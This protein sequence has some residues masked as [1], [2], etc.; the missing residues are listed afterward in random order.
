VCTKGRDVISG[1]Q[2]QT[3]EAFSLSISLLPWLPKKQPGVFY[4]ASFPSSCYLL[5][6]LLNHTFHT[7][8]HSHIYTFTHSHIHSFTHSLIQTFTH[9]HIHTFTHS[10]IHSFTH[11]HI[12]NQLLHRRFNQQLFC[13]GRFIWLEQINL[14]LER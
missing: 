10:H 7:F 12:H 2:W 9:S 3:N 4:A 14:T 6:F 8:T 13:R 1:K 5:S 11:S